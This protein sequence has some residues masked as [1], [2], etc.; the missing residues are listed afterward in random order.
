MTTDDYGRPLIDDTPVY[1]TLSG[2]RLST[3][4]RATD[5]ATFDTVG[6]QVGLLRYENPAQDAVVDEDGNVIT[7]AVPASGAI[8]P[9]QGNTVVRLGPHVI[10]PATY[11]DEGNELTPAV[12]DDRYHANFTLGPEAT[13]REEWVAWIEQWMAN[14]TLAQQNKSEVALLYQGVEVID[15]AS[16]SSPSNVLL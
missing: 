4:V 10:T 8:I 2:G 14:G 13:A 15:P 16:I 5:E 11:D 12:M 7:E 9:T 3:M 1:A 6:L